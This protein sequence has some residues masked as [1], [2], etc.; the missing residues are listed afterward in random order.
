MD[1]AQHRAAALGQ[2]RLLGADVLALDFDRTD[3]AV[4]QRVAAH[5]VQHR[6]LVLLDLLVQRIEPELAVPE[7]LLA[8]VDQAALLRQIGGEAVEGFVLGAERLDHLGQLLLDGGAVLLERLDLL[9]DLAELLLCVVLALLRR[10]HAGAGLHQLVLDPLPRLRVPFELLALLGKL[11]LLRRQ[12]GRGVVEAEAGVLHL[13]LQLGQLR[14]LG[15]VVV[16]GVREAQLGQA[17]G[18]L[19]VGAGPPGLDL[20]AAQALL[21]LLDDVVHAQ[22]VLVDLLELPQRLLLPRLEL[23]DARGLL[24][25]DRIFHAHDLPSIHPEDPFRRPVEVHDGAGQV[26]RYDA[27]GHRLVPSRYRRRPTETSSTSRWSMRDPS[28]R[29]GLSKTRV[30]SATPDGLRPAEPLKITSSMASPR[31]LLALCS[32][33]THLNPSTTLLLP[34]PLGP[35]IPVIGESNTNSVRS[36]KLLKP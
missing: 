25:D 5:Q 32:P 1:L 28:S 14:V 9:G 17:M 6:R 4:Q 7:G 20:H 15:V 33:R 26:D 19:L 30:T 27:A 36:A 23:A 34:Q 2:A 16:Q 8:L 29:L 3:P 12:V 18:M 10:L 13:R 22:E 31:R 11:V 35:T 21:D 24:E